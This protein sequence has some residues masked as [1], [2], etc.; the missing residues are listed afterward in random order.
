MYWLGFVG[1]S[2]WCCWF[3]FVWHLDVNWWGGGGVF[4]ICFV[5]CECFVRCFWFWKG[6]VVAWLGFV[7][8]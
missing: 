2:L 4:F 1:C 7:V 5:V 8:S 6:F 3:L